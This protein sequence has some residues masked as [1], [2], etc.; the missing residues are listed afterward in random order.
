M[1]GLGETVI[2][3]DQTDGFGMARMGYIR[4]IDG[5]GEF[6]TIADVDELAS[7][8]T[9]GEPATRDFTV[10][11]GVFA[12]DERTYDLDTT[13]VPPQLTLEIDR[14]GVVPF[15]VGIGAFNVRY[16]LARNCPPCDQVDMPVDDAEW[17]L[18]NEVAVTV[19]AS[20]VNP[21]RSE[22]HY[23]ETRTVTG[24]PRNLLP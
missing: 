18:V 13:T 14:G 16:I 6:F 1:H 9:R 8:I 15:A 23:S 4:H 24:K 2:T 19:T 21:I 5:D 7:T 20:T 11:S 22:D 10:G 17:R 12:V 3:V